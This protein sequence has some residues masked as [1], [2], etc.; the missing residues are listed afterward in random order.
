MQKIRVLFL[1]ANPFKT[2][3]SE[4][5]AKMHAI[6]YELHSF[7]NLVFDAEWVAGVDD[8]REA[9]KFYQPH[10][11]HFVG[12]GTDGN[13]SLENDEGRQEKNDAEACKSSQQES[14]DENDHPQESHSR[15]HEGIVLPVNAGELKPVA[16]LVL[17]YLFGSFNERIR[18]IILD[19]CY[20][21]EQA[22][23]LSTKEGVACV[24]GIRAIT[25]ASNA[26]WFT[27]V[28]YS[29]ISRGYTIQ[30]AFKKGELAVPS[31]T[32]LK[33]QGQKPVELL[34]ATKALWP[35]FN[36]K[37]TKDNRGSES[38]ARAVINSGSQ[39]SSPPRL[40]PIDLFITYADE[41]Q[42][43]RDELI[44]YLG[45]LRNQELI[46]IW[47]G[48]DVSLQKG[49][50]QVLKH[51]NKAKVILLLI[52]PAFI[53][54]RFVDSGEMRSATARYEHGEAYVISVVLRPVDWE[55][56]RFSR[57]PKLSGGDEPII[58][59]SPRDQALGEVVRSIRLIIEELQKTWST[60]L[61]HSVEQPSTDQ[62]EVP[63]KPL[64]RDELRDIFVT[65]GIPRVTFVK[66]E[67]FTPLVTALKT[68]GLSVVIEGPS[69]IGKTTIVQMAINEIQA[70]NPT[71]GSAEPH[72]RLIAYEPKHL[73]DLKT[74]RDCHEYGDIVIID[75]F[76]HQELELRKEIVE[77]LKELAKT[78]QE[79]KKLVIMSTP[80][81]DLELVNLLSG[82]DRIICILLG[83]VEDSDV[84]QMINKGEQALNIKLEPE[85]DL[86]K[87]ACGSLK[88]AQELCLCVCHRVG[89]LNTKVQE[90]PF[91]VYYG[92][93][94]ERAIRQVMDG[95]PPKFSATPR[96]WLRLLKNLI[97]YENGHLSLFRP[98]KS[99]D[100]FVLDINVDCFKQW[101]E[102]LYQ[103]F[104]ESKEY[105]F[106][107]DQRK[108]EWEI[109]DPRFIFYL[110]NRRLHAP[111]VLL[112]YPNKG[113]ANKR[114]KQL[115]IHLEP[116]ERDGIICVED[117]TK[118]LPGDDQSS[119][120]DQFIEDCEVA[121]PLVDAEFL[122]SN[123]TTHQL[124]KLLSLAKC[125]KTTIIPLIIAPCS[126]ESTDLA[127]YKPINPD[128]PL[129]KM[130]PDKAEQILVE[131]VEFIKQKFPKED[132]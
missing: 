31:S 43:L 62:R 17:E 114:S 55:G 22:N 38:S 42:M 36:P 26:L 63:V 34:Q 103:K 116:L 14:S 57:L 124:P 104:P 92:V 83:K 100:G 15:T 121:I 68:K 49:S 24:I 32:H 123:F 9:L 8:L 110:A 94:K 122:N 88:I 66:T 97:S 86:V 75:D 76:H 58:E 47:H 29:H 59:E 67:Q 10:V 129:R 25:D 40:E 95:L 21:D 115:R 20:T 56:S 65:S 132:S 105:F 89:V 64:V 107:F 50:Q 33:L 108:S 16:N 41:D 3:L 45:V 126:W 128:R 44:E 117:I 28:F 118:V 101:M 91:L 96:S 130:T 125:R 39:G 35:S 106:F 37:P 77:Y 99:K 82:K 7:R 51:F 74:L 54:S 90:D 80:Q 53:D 79:T 60:P 87:A 98:K 46:N 81:S 48:S 78:G 70:E 84:R 6:R 73:E 127:R 69:G 131:L 72:S 19:R 111:C 71:W 5:E 61:Q 120:L 102:S 52:S 23:V 27:T 93:E 13:G 30:E 113:V 11:V 85:D 119:A 18:L 4:L 12:C 2:T 109:C 112:C 1:G